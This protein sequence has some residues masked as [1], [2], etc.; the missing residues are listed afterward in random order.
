MGL[1]QWNLGE[2]SESNLNKN[3]DMETYRENLW[4]RGAPLGQMTQSLRMCR[5]LG[6]FGNHPLLGI[7]LTVPLV[8]ILQ[9]KSEPPSCS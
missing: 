5:A 7:V 6:I 1:K 8:P 9:E 3:K 4:I 2:S